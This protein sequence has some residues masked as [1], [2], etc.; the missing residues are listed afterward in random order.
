MSTAD[1]ERKQPMPRQAGTPDARRAEE[2]G[3]V[4]RGSS[5]LVLLAVAALLISGGLVVASP[6]LAG[7]AVVELPVFSIAHPGPTAPAAQGAPARPA[8]NQGGFFGGMI[9]YR[10]ARAEDMPPA[11][12]VRH[13]G[14]AGGGQQLMS[15]HAA[16]GATPLDAPHGGDVAPPGSPAPAPLALISPGAALP[17]HPKPLPI[18]LILALVLGPSLLLVVQALRGGPKPAVR[19]A[20]RR[21]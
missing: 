19:P 20:R 6:I 17:A 5:H 15:G 12:A 10:S 21:Y 9:G 13:D 14:P 4:M 16:L 7:G 3:S 1:V 18:V 2:G 11:P 8:A